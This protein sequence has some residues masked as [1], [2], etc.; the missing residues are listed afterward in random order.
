M[1]LPPLAIVWRC[2]LA[3]E[4]YASDGK[5]V[6]SE[7]SDAGPALASAQ[8]TDA[9]A[10]DGSKVPL[11][12][13]GETEI[14]LQ[15]RRRDESVGHPKT[16]LAPDASGALRDGAVDGHLPE[17]GEHTSGNVG[18]RC[19]RKELGTGD[20]RVVKPV[21]ARLELD[22]AAEVVDEDVGVNQNVRHGPTR[23]GLVFAR[24]DPIRRSRRG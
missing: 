20:D 14:A 22:G 21:A 9:K 17:R 3:V 12:A 19:P 4:Q 7:P 13:G 5:E 10:P 11:V 8:G 1:V 24:R 2:P 15:G 6:V 23:R 18:S 16:A